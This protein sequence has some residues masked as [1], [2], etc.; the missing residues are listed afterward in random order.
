MLLET[1]SGNYGIERIIL[2]IGLNVNQVEFPDDL[3]TKA[4]SL[5][6]EC[7]L[8][9]D[10]IRLLQKI[11]EELENR[12][13]QL[14]RFSAGQL[15]NDWRMKALLFGKKITVLENEFSFTATAIDV[16]DDGSLIIETEEGRKRNIF[17]GDV[18]LAYR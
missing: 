5:T 10:R 17:A 4:T 14:S 12:Y 6:V 9:V 3:I 7:G 2:G 8:E 1:S 15:L 16:A 18:S 11:L 13:E